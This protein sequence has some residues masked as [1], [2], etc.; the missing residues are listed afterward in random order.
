MRESNFEITRAKFEVKVDFLKLYHK[1]VQNVP[2]SVGQLV[3][4]SLDQ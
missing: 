1:A 2:K 4:R 3:I